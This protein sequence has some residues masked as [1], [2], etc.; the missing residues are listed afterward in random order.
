[1]VR[2]DAKEALYQIV[3]NNETNNT[4][5]PSDLAKEL[6]P[7][8]QV[9]EAV[10][11]GYNFWSNLYGDLWMTRY[12]ILGLGFGAS[13]VRNIRLWQHHQQSGY[14]MHSALT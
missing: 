9:T 12:Y 6:V 5:S 14:R 13:L 11:G 3:K 4:L 1:M 2:D 8:N 7:E 10:K